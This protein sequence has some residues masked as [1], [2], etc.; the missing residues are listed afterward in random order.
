M[1]FSF[2]GQISVYTYQIYFLPDK[3]NLMLLQIIS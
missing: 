3:M 1:F 2:P